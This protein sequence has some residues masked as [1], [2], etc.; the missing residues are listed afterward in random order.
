MAQSIQ[1]DDVAATLAARRELGGDYEE[2][3]ADALV[4]RIGNTIDERIDAKL[5]TRPPGRT[6]VKISPSTA[7]MVSGLGMGGFFALAGAADL[8][9]AAV[10]WLVLAVSAIAF[11]LGR[12]RAK[13]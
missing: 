13:S 10:L 11:V 4:E 6:G 8:Q 2:A 5:A 3:L 12:W 1:R 9:V 7:A